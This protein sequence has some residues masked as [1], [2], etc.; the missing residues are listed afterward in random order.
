MQPSNQCLH[1]KKNV[2]MDIDYGHACYQLCIIIII[3]MDDNGHKDDDDTLKKF[4]L[5]CFIKKLLQEL[6]TRSGCFFPSS[7]S[8]DS[9]I[10]LT[11]G[12]LSK[13]ASIRAMTISTICAIYHSL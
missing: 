3:I 8:D 1:E 11:F 4:T 12:S 10:V 7:K 9:S 5:E 6:K 2:Y 13:A